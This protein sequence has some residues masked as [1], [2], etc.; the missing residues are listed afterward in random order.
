MMKSGS[1]KIPKTCKHPAVFRKRDFGF[2]MSDF[3]ELWSSRSGRGVAEIQHPAS[4]ILQICIGVIAIRANQ[5]RSRKD[6][7]DTGAEL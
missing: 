3:G 4:V 5:E 6:P 2:R 7:P 1:L